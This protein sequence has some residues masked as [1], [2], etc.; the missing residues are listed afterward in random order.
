[1]LF[2]RL[3]FIVVAMWIMAFPEMGRGPR[4]DNIVIN[5]QANG[6]NQ[7]DNNDN[8]NPP[9]ENELDL[10]ESERQMSAGARLLASARSAR[11]RPVI[12][13]FLF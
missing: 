4:N 11:Q 8:T 2:F 7:T 13:N 5:N 12:N 3:V 10:N 9:N 6:D 1:M